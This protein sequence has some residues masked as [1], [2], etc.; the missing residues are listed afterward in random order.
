MEKIMADITMCKGN[1]CERKEFC[2]RYT[3]TPCKYRQ[4]YFL[5]VPLTSEGCSYFYNNE[6][7]K[8][9]SKSKEST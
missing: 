8:D 5:E 6:R 7:M 1:N 2:Y 3:A 9:G 4:A